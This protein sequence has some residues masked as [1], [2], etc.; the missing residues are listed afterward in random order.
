M[1]WNSSVSGL[2]Q[3]PPAGFSSGR[4]WWMIWAKGCLCCDVCAHVSC[5]GLIGGLFKG[6]SNTLDHTRTLIALAEALVDI[7][8][9][10][11][12]NMVTRLVNN[13]WC[14]HHRAIHENSLPLS[15]RWWRN[16]GVMEIGTERN[17]WQIQLARLQLRV[18][19]CWVRNVGTVTVVFELAAAKQASVST[20]STWDN[21]VVSLH[22]VKI[23]YSFIGKYTSPVLI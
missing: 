9:V 22:L 18:Q 19:L 12:V 15:M 3:N 20:R 7:V 23:F 8:S 5:K 6:N 17:A 16:L 10:G 2:R 4:A 14:R 21:R 11:K 13:E 1:S